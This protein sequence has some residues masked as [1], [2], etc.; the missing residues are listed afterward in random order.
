MCQLYVLIVETPLFGRFINHIKL[1]K[2]NEKTY[3][4][5]IHLRKEIKNREIRLKVIICFKYMN[6]IYMLIYMTNI[7]DAAEK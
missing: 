6:K 3:E 5:K 4:I 7:V 2:L 1:Y